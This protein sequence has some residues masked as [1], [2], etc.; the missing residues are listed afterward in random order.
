[1]WDKKILGGLK[2]YLFRHR[3]HTGFIPVSEIGFIPRFQTL[4]AT[5]AAQHGFIPWFRVFWAP[6]FHCWFHTGFIP[7]RFTMV[8]S[9]FGFLCF[10]PGFGL[11]SDLGE[12]P[13]FHTV[14]SYIVCLLTSLI[15]YV[16]SYL[17]FIPWFLHGFIPWFHRDETK[18]AVSASG[19]P[20]VISLSI[21]R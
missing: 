13:W 2:P 3:F 19:K 4:R 17:G 18:A 10:M 9:S 7:G 12:I 20:S 16:V 1:M 14:V 15:V 21:A 5:L 11:V 8:P 6:L